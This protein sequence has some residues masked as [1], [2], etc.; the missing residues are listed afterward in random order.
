MRTGSLGHFSETWFQSLSWASPVA[1]YSARLV[2]QPGCG[3]RLPQP[4]QLTLG[5]ELLGYHNN[6]NNSIPSFLKGQA[7]T[8]HI[9]SHIIPSSLPQ[10]SPLPCSPSL[11]LH[12]SLE[13][14]C[15]IFML[16]QKELLLKYSTKHKPVKYR[17][18]SIY[19]SIYKGANCRK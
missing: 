19:Y 14:V 18:P 10:T 13:P 15:I 12:T 11:R 17:L 4:G 5:E 1:T 16:I 8:L 6:N 7:K 2:G 3:C 9:S